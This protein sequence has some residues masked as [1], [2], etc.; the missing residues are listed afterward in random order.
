MIALLGVKP[1]AN[2]VLVDNSSNHAKSVGRA[3]RVCQ[4]GSFVLVAIAPVSLRERSSASP[5]IVGPDT[6]F[7][8]S[9]EKGEE[10]PGAYRT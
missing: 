1:F 7:S 5:A 10:G 9:S 4:S 3:G 8:V 6:A 2:A